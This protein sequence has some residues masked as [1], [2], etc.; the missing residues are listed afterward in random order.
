VARLEQIVEAA[1]EI[2]HQKGY[3]AGSLDDVAEALDLRKASLYHY[4]N[5]KGQLLYHVFDRALTI[6]LAR[7]YELEAT[8]TGPV[9]RLVALISHQVSIVAE[10]RS[11]F[12][13]FFSTRPRLDEEYEKRILELERRY[14]HHYI[15]AVKAAMDADAIPAGNP[16]YAA[17]AILG[18]S[19]WVY[20]W[21]DPTHDD[22]S[23]VCR[24]FVQLILHTEMSVA[25][26]SSKEM[27]QARKQ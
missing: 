14:L 7:L 19:S 16:R 24:T 15:D 2:F 26:P 3:D 1:A 17:Q 23:D 9:E 12:S 18:M 21:F 25:M 22:W 20:K 11:M 5:S 6:G 8:N 27:L 13:V 10:E 4:V